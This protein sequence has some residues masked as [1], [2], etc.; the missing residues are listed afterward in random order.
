ML[1]SARFWVKY[2]GIS[3][4]VEQKSSPAAEPGADPLRE[5]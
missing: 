5:E 2:V 3:A 1:A 4:R